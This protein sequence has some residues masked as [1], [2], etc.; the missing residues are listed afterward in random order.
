MPNINKVAT[1]NIN[2]VTAEIK[3]A[4]LSEFIYRHGFDIVLLQ[5]VVQPD[6]VDIPRYTPYVNIGSEQRGTAI[7]LK[8]GICAGRVNRIPTGRGMSIEIGNVWYVNVYAPS[9]ADKRQEREAFFNTDMLMLLPTAPAEMVIAGDFNCV[10][11]TADTTGATPCSKTLGRIITG[12]GMHDAWDVKSA[13]VGYTH[14]APGSATRLDRIYVTGQLQVRKSGM[15]VLAPAFTDH[16]AVVIRLATDVPLLDRGRG[17]WKMNASLM[18]EEGFQKDLKVHWRKWVTHRRFY[19]TTV[20]WWSRYV[21]VQIK[22]LFCVKGAERYRERKAMENF[23]YAAIYDVI[24]SGGETH[25]MHEALGVLKERITRLYAAPNRSLFLGSE[26]KDQCEQEQPSIYHMVRQWKR[27]RSNQM[28]SIRDG[29][30][31]VH[32]EGRRILRVFTE[33]IE[34]KFREIRINRTAMQKILESVDQRVTSEENK[35]LAAPITREELHAAV[36]RGKKLKAPGP[37]GV[38]AEFFRTA[39]G[40]IQVEL[41]EMMNNM[42]VDG[43]ILPPQLK[44]MIVYVPKIRRPETPGDYRGLTL[45]NSDVKLLARILVHRLSPILRTLL[46][47]GQHC[48]VQGN[49]ILDAIATI[50]DTIADA[51]MTNGTLCILSLDFSEA[52]DRVTHEYLYGTLEKYGFD[53]W[54]IDRIR[55]M[56][57]G[58]TSVAQINGYVSREIPI[59]RSI[60]QGCPLSMLLFALCIDPFIRRLEE[61]IGRCRR[62]T[63]GRR[64]VVVAYA[65]DVTIILRAPA[66]LAVVDKVTREFELASGALLNTTK[67]KALGIGAWDTTITMRGILY[68]PQVTILGITFGATTSSTVLASWTPVV[69]SICGLAKEVYQRSLSLHQRCLY[70]NAFLLA[71]AWFT[72]QLIPPPTAV[73]RRINTAITYMIWRGSIFRVPITTLCKPKHQGGMGVVHT[74]AKCRALLFYRLREQ[75]NRAGS[76]TERLLQRWGLLSHSKNPPNLNRRLLACAYLQEHALDMAYIPPRTVMEMTKGYK[77]RIYTSMLALLRKT[78]SEP[79]MRIENRSPET[80][81]TY[82]WKNLWTAPVP[83]KTKNEWYYIIHDIVPTRERLGVINLTQSV[84]CPRCNTPDTLAHRITE[85][86]DGKRQWAWT[87][88]RL[89]VILRTDQRH[90]PVSWLLRPAFRLWPAP[91]HRAVLWLLATFVEYRMGRTLTLSLQN[92]IDFLARE[93]IRLD[94]L[95]NRPALVGNYLSVLDM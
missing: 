62:N 6:V 66:E 44:G 82:V 58:A 35:R 13:G 78:P 29:D 27:K 26:E 52:F 9:G 43:M 94:N 48:G 10:V 38:S 12:L 18:E 91:R 79:T 21:K 69:N 5:E 57:E 76:E 3:K 19:Q 88:M 23:Y 4:M 22:K 67:S 41:L 84:L 65:D 36:I 72:A 73:L 92:Y 8:E 61:E 15:E 2:G 59:R 40:V 45:L 55:K 68:Y 63:H 42:Y 25:R 39:W 83:D 80:N 30:G 77:R 95:R 20:L 50:R 14:Y 28:G 75:A 37:D 24:G 85:C 81:W 34:N 51:E 16:M 64:E 53:G 46:H 32:T 70:A 74:E 56:Y 86:G 7:L 49:T 89:A 33:I 87:R 60:R 31:I 1:I 11:N 90:I 71:K 17:M 93:K 47:P 54:V